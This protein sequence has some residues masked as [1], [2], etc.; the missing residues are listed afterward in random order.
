MDNAGQERRREANRRDYEKSKAQQDRLLLRLDKGDLAR[1]DRA[2]KAAGLS[3]AA[4]VRM[5]LAPTLGAVADHLPAIEKARAV[6]GSSLAQFLCS[7]IAAALAEP[8]PAPSPTVAAEFDAL[9]GP[10]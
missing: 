7:A 2:S 4:F 9:F 5:F 1:L 10:D 3:R 6:N 8:P